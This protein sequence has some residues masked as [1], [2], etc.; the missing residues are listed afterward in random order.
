MRH[1]SACDSRAC[2]T[3]PWTGAG[4]RAGCVGGRL[5]G[6]S[7]ELRPSPEYGAPIVNALV[8]GEARLVYGN[9]ENTGLIDN[10]PPGC[11]VEV[12]VVIDRTG[13]RPCLV[14]ALPP[15]CAGMCVQ[16]LAVQELVV[17]AALERNRE[18]VYHA[19]ML[20]RHAASALNL[21][22]PRALVGEL[23]DAHDAAMPEG[24]RT[25]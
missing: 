7:F 13:P 18:H 14:G 3:E 25:R 23:L 4:R 9:V 24:V 16:H 17:R 5:E 12:P 10:L 22:Q 15:Q 6:G 19:A 2:V 8:T 21:D 11:C 20:D 1:V